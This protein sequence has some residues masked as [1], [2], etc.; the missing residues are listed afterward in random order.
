MRCSSS[1]FSD[2]QDQRPDGRR[3]RSPNLI[4]N[5]RTRR[6]GEK[7]K[8]DFLASSMKRHD[9][10][11]KP[12]SNRSSFMSRSFFFSFFSVLLLLNFLG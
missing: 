1:F 11:G 12:K 10:A 8:S 7:E 4:E 9:E 3:E 5:T 6:D 2:G